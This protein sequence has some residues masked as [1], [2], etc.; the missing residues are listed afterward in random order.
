MPQGQPQQAL[1]VLGQGL[2]LLGQG[3]QPAGA[4]AAGEA[5]LQSARMRMA[6]AEVEADRS[7]WEQ[8]AQLAAEAL[9]ACGAGPQSATT[10][11]AAAALL[12]KALLVRGKDEAA[13][14]ATARLVQAARSRPAVD[15][16]PGSTGGA[17]QW[18]VL[19]R[20]LGLALS[21]QHATGACPCRRSSLPFS[22]LFPFCC[23]ALRCVLQEACHPNF[24]GTDVCELP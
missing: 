12:T 19:S 18:G 1:D 24:A 3:Q 23:S 5:G 10:A 15:T 7:G 16:G 2:S 17:S 11:A 14:A 6:M 13:A 22:P 8:A 4:A 21:T 9:S 20:A